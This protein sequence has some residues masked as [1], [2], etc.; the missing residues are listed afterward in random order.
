MR[1]AVADFISREDAAMQDYEAET[2]SH[3]PFR[4]GGG[5]CR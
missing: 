5:T 2:A 3:L 4:Q 1:R